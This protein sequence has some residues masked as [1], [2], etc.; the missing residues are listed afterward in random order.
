MCMSQVTISFQNNLLYYWYINN[1]A[2]RA[3]SIDVKPVMICQ[4]FIVHQL[5]KK[6]MLHIWTRPD[7]SIGWNRKHDGQI[8]K[9]FWIERY[10]R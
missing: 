3:D 5:F 6:Y 9:I 1:I 2:N 7:R 10:S 8:G 4:A